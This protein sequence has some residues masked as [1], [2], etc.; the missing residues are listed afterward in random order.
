MNLVLRGLGLVGKDKHKEDV[1]CGSETEDRHYR[2]W[3]HR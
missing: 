2:L 3:R 1:V